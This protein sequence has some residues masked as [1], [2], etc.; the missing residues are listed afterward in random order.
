MSE[1]RPVER[2][3]AAA[4]VLVRELRAQRALRVGYHDEVFTVWRHRRAHAW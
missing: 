4:P 2:V 1:P 3:L